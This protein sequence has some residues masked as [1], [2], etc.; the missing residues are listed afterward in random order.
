M[1]QRGKLNGMFQ[2][3]SVFHD[4]NVIEEGNYIDDKK[5]G[6]WKKYGFDSLNTPLTSDFYAKGKLIKHIDHFKKSNLSDALGKY[7]IKRIKK[8]DTVSEV[9]VA[10]ILNGD[11][12]ITKPK[13]MKSVTPELDKEIMKA[14]LEA[15]LFKPNL[16]DGKPIARKMTSHL[17]PIQYQNGVKDHEMVVREEEFGKLWSPL[18]AIALAF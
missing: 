15:P 17:F 1:Y 10:F 8:L 14:Y 13:L 12:K 18:G 3:F 5:D 16:Y 4:H 11:G 7:L 2:Y 6:E 9:S